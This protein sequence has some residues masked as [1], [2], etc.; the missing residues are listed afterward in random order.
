MMSRSAERTTYAVFVITGNGC[1]PIHS[2]FVGKLPI[3]I[4]V[5]KIPIPRTD[6]RLGVCEATVIYRVLPRS[7]RRVIKQ[8]PIKCEDPNRAFV[9]E[10]MGHLLE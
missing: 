9:C 3:A 10:H 7:A 6:Y 4:W 1:K 5:E 8:Y 2:A